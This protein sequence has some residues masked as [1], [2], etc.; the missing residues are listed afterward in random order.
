MKIGLCIAPIALL[1]YELLIP[2]Y[3]ITGIIFSL[4]VPALSVFFAHLYFVK[5]IIPFDF[6]HRTILTHLFAFAGFCTLLILMEN[7]NLSITYKLLTKSFV[8]I[9][10]VIF[11][12]SYLKRVISDVLAV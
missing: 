1:C 8:I 7:L 4:L 5:E 3:K 2:E 10:I 11:A 9:M 6:P 12:K